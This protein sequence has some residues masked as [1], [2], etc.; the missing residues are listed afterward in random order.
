[1]GRIASRMVA[2][3]DGALG[4]FASAIAAKSNLSPRDALHILRS[5]FHEVR[6]AERGRELVGVEI[7]SAALFGKVRAG[8]S[9]HASLLFSHIDCSVSGEQFG[10]LGKLEPVKS[11]CRFAMVRQDDSTAART[12]AFDVRYAPGF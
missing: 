3:F 6:V 2:A 7:S 10:S 11:D 9:A 4:E 5:A 1:M 8:S 12:C